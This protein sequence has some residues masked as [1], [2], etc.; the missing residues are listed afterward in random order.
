MSKEP[1]QDVCFVVSPIGQAGSDQRRHADWVLNG[2]I[3]PVFD[4][5]YPDF[6]VER[7]DKITEPG[8]INA[9]VIDRL[10]HSKLVIA[11]LS[12]LNANVFYE[13]GIRHMAEMPI[14]HMQRVDEVI[15]FDVSI[16]RA[17]KFSLAEFDHIET[18]K[19]QLTNMLVDVLKPDYVPNNPVTEARG[20]AKLKESATPQEQIVMEDLS[21]L[22]SRMEALESSFMIGIDDQTRANLILN[23]QSRYKFRDSAIAQLYAP[24]LSRKSIFPPSSEDMASIS[25]PTSFM[26]DANIEKLM[27]L[28]K[29]FA[30]NSTSIGFDHDADTINIFGPTKDMMVLK[31]VLEKSNLVSSMTIS[32]NM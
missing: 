13:V 32:T 14:I 11:D 30:G 31:S 27:N 22:R 1:T 21:R 24:K 25:V 3:K 17:I 19:L 4:K 8:Q 16:Y 5:S 9:Q 20:R 12:F 18:A 6:K 23:N 28:I 7:A 2:I 10:H 29:G 15:P 26:I